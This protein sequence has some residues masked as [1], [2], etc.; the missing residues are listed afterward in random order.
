MTKTEYQNL[1]RTKESD[2]QA[3]I[4]EWCAWNMGRYPELE[5]L[6]H[7][8]NGGKRSKPEAARFKREGVKAGVPDLCL[9]VA[10]RGFHGL[11]IELKAEGGVVS[12]AQEK[13]IAGLKRQNYC[14]FVVYGAAAAIKALEFYLGGEKEK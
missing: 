3:M 7:I 5:L 13:W 6:Y 10:R 11:Y 2:E 4:F 9:P 14:A 12:D 8:P 1:Y